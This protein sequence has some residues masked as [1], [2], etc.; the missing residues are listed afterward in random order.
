MRPRGWE[1]PAAVA[2]VA[3]VIALFRRPALRRRAFSEAT[4]PGLA[5]G[6]MVLTF[7]AGLVGAMQDGITAL[8]EGRRPSN[9]LVGVPPPWYAET[10]QVTWTT[11]KLPAGLEVPA[12]LLYLGQSDGKVVLYDRRERFR[13]TLVLPAGA[14]A[15]AV[16]HRRAQCP[17]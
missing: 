11:G 10:A 9:L 2:G 17:R 15:I 3:S 13:R 8:R 1:L 4:R 5:V 12:C 14:V 7:A 16:T 6:L